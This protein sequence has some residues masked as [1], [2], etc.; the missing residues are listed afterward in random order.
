M[1]RDCSHLFPLISILLL[2]SALSYGQ[3]WSGI[4]STS[5]AI[6]WS[7]AGLQAT[8]PDGETTLNPWTPPTRTLCTTL[9]PSG[10]SSGAQDITNITNAIAGCGN[11]SYVLM[12]GTSSTP[13][14]IG[15]YLRISPGYMSGHNN[16][17]LRG[18][19]PMTTYVNMLGTSAIQIGV[20]VA[21]GSAPLTND[22]SNFTV[23][24]TSVKITTTSPPAVGMLAY[25]QQCDTGVT[26]N[27][28]ACAN[29]TPVDNNGLFVC[30]FDSACQSGSGTCPHYNDQQQYVLITSVTNSGGGTYTIG[31]SNG[32]YMNNWSFA[33]AAQLNWFSS[34]YTG[35]GYG[36]EDMTVVFQSGANQSAGFNGCVDCWIKGVRMIGDAVNGSS[37]P[38]ASK[39]T[40]IANNYIFGQNP[41]MSGNIKFAFNEG[42][43]SDNLILNN[44][45]TAGTSWEGEGFQT[46]NVFAYNYNRDMLT[47]YNQ[48]EIRHHGEASFILEEGNQQIAVQDDDTWG[49]HDFNTWFRNYHSC[50]DPPYTVANFTSRALEID[51]YARFENVIGNILGSSKCTTG[52]QTQNASAFGNVYILAATDTLSVKSLYRWGNCDSSTNTCRFQ[53]SENP[54]TLTGNAAPFNNISS[55]SSTLPCSFF[56][57]GY[58]STTCTPH[59][60]GGTGL[61]WWKV[62]TNWTTFP[63]SCAAYQTQPFPPIGPDVSGGPYSVGT[64]SA[65]DIP[66]AIAHNNLP[67][68]PAYQ[69]SYSITG[70]SWSNGTETLTVSGLPNISHLMGG[71]QL[72]GVPACN[73]AAGGEFLMTNSSAT[74]ISYALASNPGS[75]AG[76]TMKFPDL[77]Q[78]DERV[79]EDDPSSN[80]N[81]PNPPTGLTADVK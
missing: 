75:C 21:G 71:F 31:I 9:G 57:A 52:Y 15:N 59:A 43:D 37:G 16:V 29:G 40:L 17:T 12:T 5:R 51:N 47:T 38:F 4:L 32:L 20:G 68:D 77:R 70:S 53:G 3:S 48:L 36:L 49:T 66:A 35:Y 42:Q 69:M 63:T 64:G 45:L 22:S 18:S 2:F 76:G 13:F 7:Q 25:L 54:T 56:L 78:F 50:W 34:T 8:F 81:P 28:T 41:A 61:N 23:G 60:N 27:G 65:Y 55:P 74:T 1:R 30:A 11:G 72:T 33:Q 24:S 39:N 19:G 26:W 80:G 67:I 46:G 62:C 73:S 44:I 6:D 10:D 79:Y 14:Y 58:T